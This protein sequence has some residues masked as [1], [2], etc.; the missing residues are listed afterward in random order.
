[1]SPSARLNTTIGSDFFSYFGYES[2]LLES[3][4]KT[5]AEEQAEKKVEATRKLSLRQG[6]DQKTAA[7]RK[8]KK[9][10]TDKM[11]K[12]RRRTREQHHIIESADVRHKYGLAD[13]T[14]ADV[15]WHRKHGK[16]SSLFAFAQAMRTDPKKA[17][18]NQA[19]WE[20]PVRVHRR[21][22]AAHAVQLNR[23]MDA[24]GLADLEGAAA[25]G[26][27]IPSFGA[28]LA[29]RPAEREIAEHD[30]GITWTTQ[31]ATGSRLTV[32]LLRALG[33]K[34][35]R[36]QERLPDGRRV[37]VR[38]LDAKSVALMREKAKPAV[39]RYLDPEQARKD[40]EAIEEKTF[41]VPAAT[42]AWQLTPEIEAAM[43]AS[44]EALLSEEVTE[45]EPRAA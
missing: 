4:T 2:E 29:T 34:A 15:E 20:G 37:W 25:S 16:K 24:L 27:T 28:Y 12:E 26:Q 23:W 8:E 13:L 3:L 44:F 35:H 19:E 7:A 32:A 5:V 30:F 40:W 18:E 45:P 9:S 43:G 38:T 21:H 42:L 6:G 36:H 39:Q 22:R 14:A 31:D 10:V 1:M 17:S 41:V 11:K 33:L